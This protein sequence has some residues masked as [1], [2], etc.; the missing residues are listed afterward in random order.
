MIN[1]I[2]NWKW[3]LKFLIKMEPEPKTCEHK[4]KISRCCSECYDKVILNRFKNDK[5]YP[6]NA[7]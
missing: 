4:V 6:C 7:E 5:K 3:L 2:F 1:K